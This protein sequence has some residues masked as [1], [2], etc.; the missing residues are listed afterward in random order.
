MSASPVRRN[1]W[2]FSFA[3][4]FN[5]VASEAAIR[6]IPL[7]LS[8][9]LNTGLPLI[10]LIEG[11]A[12]ATA[13]LVKPASGWL[14]DRLPRRKPLVVAGYS[15]SALTKYLLLFANHW[16]WMLFIRFT[17][18][19]GKGIRSAP[20]DAMIADEAHISA[21]GASFG[22]S[23]TLDT[24]GAM[25][26]LLLSAYVL[27]HSHTL[28]RHEFQHVILLTLIPAILAA[29]VVAWG[30]VETHQDRS[31][32]VH[33][34][35]ALQR[36]RALPPSFWRYMAVVGLFTLANSSDAFLI[37]KLSQS[38]HAGVSVILLCLVAMNLSS[39]LSALPAGRLSDRFGRRKV[40]AFGWAVYAVC[41]MLFGFGHSMA[42]FFPAFLL[43]GVFYGFTESA[44]KAFV[45]DLVTAQQGR[46]LGYGV[47]ALV[48]GLLSIPASLAFGFLMKAL[49]GTIPFVLAGGLSALSAIVLIA[50]V[51]ETSHPSKKLAT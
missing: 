43:Y 13:T 10:G 28:G 22:V 31:Q 9:V 20:R 23:Q 3:S 19:V 48:V 24:L 26:G 2:A 1:L 15:L 38:T 44:E 33:A 34:P 8:Q 29:V 5:D 41:Y 39:T 37:L 47:F 14:A 6:L 7:F 49:G 36:A 25:V 40:I 18:R 51:P 27:R 17:D 4:F 50:W 12:N 30:V 16:V 35:R 11:I 32:G 21:R 45:A 46:G 42:V